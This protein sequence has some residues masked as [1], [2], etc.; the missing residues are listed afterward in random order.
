MKKLVLIIGVMILINIIFAVVMRAQEQLTPAKS[1]T[2]TG[3]TEL[4]LYEV[5]LSITPLEKPA[6]R[7]VMV[8]HHMMANGLPYVIEGVGVADHRWFLV[9]FFEP[10]QEEAYIIT[11][12]RL[13]VGGMRGTWITRDGDS[14]KEECLERTE[15]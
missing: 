1:Y 7:I 13:G 11:A 9:S 10:N 5:M 12:Y 14:Y 4:G 2:C 6:Y 15:P 8:D 3:K